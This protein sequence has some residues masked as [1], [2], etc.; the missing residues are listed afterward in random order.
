MLEAIWSLKIIK[1]T[2]QVH[3]ARRKV[4]VLATKT[5]YSGVVTVNSANETEKF[6]AI[7]LI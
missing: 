3:S 5:A 6:M 4:G 2:I 7:L 1:L